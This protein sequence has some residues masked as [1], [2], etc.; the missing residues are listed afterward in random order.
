M[1]ITYDEWYEKYKPLGDLYGNPI[2][3]ETFGADLEAVQ[4]TKPEYI[5][6]FVDGGDYSGYSSGMHFVN[7]MYYLICEVPFEEDEDLYVDLYEPDEC[8]SIGHVFEKRERYTGAEFNVC[9]Y[10]EQDEDDLD[11]E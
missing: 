2:T 1:N 9:I 11:N 6:T 7:R 5:W 8:E 10:C 4:E 3:F